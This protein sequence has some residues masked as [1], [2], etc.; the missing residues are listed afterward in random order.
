MT[1]QDRSALVIDDVP[2]MRDLLMR[3][4][5]SLGFAK[6]VGLGSPEE[7]LGLLRTSTF[8]VILVDWEMT[9]MTGLQFCRQVR[10]S[11][12]LPAT[13]RLVMVTGHGDSQH[14][15]QARSAGIDAFLLK[16]VSREQLA[17]KIKALLAK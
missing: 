7:A 13:T 1:A 12:Q 9:P 16:P 6:T 17:S 14:V 10:S 15:L 2:A 5:R 11:G 8:D 3:M 4:L